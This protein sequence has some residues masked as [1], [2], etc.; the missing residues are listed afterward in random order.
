MK[1]E[2]R[3]V[4]SDSSRPHGLYSPWNSPGQNTG[5]CSLSLHQGIFPTQGSNSGLL[6][7]KQIRYQLSHVGS[8]GEAANL[9]GGVELRWAGAPRSSLPLTGCVSLGKSLPQPEPLLR[10]EMRTRGLVHWVVPSWCEITCVLLD[11]K[12]EP[13]ECLPL[14]Q[15][16]LTIRISLPSRLL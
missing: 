11:P 3:S 14:S 8:R 5:V 4:M 13:S 9:M 2:S 15:G 16:L 6:H 7:C 1:S 12:R 10:C